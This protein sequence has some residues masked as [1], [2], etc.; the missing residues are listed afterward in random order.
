MRIGRIGADSSG[1][2]HSKSAQPLV[3]DKGMQERLQKLISRSGI[4]S[5]R[6]AEEMIVNGEV[7]V[8]GK[9]VRVLGSKA[10][11]SV[12]HIKVRGQLINPEL[13]HQPS[14]YLLL[15]KPKGYLSS[16]SDPGHRPLVIDLIPPPLRQGLR[17]AGRLDFN[18]EGLVLLTNDGDFANLLTKAGKVPKIYEVKVKGTPTEEQIERLR[19]GIRIDRG[20]TAPAEIVLKERTREGGNAWFEVTLHEGRNQQIR[21]MFDSIGHSVTKLRRIKIGQLT[22]KGLAVGQFRELTSGE[23]KRLKEY[24]EGTARKA[25]PARKR[26]GGSNRPGGVGARKKQHQSR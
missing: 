4:A 6:A 23:V 10:D 26:G 17:L 11:P 25:A 19:R 22:D 5:R 24:Q 7:T 1:N 9:V 21:K 18:T 3:N 20:T 2:A 14:R 8:N 15:N 16:A 12:D 13:A